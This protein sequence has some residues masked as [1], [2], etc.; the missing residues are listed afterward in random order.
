M[1]NTGVASDLLLRLT[2]DDDVPALEAL[3]ELP[4]VRMSRPLRAT[5]DRG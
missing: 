3:I 2:T 4:V 1:T 5:D